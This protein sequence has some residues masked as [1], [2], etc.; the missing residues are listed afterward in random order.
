MFCWPMAFGIVISSISWLEPVAEET[1][2][3]H[4][5]Q[6]QREREEGNPN[7]AFEGMAQ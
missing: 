6:K 2:L 7:I 5:A 3:P 4:A 1:T